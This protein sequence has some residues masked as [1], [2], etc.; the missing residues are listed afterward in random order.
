MSEYQYYEF[1]AIDRTLTAKELAELRAISTRASL[2]PSSF[3]NEYEWGDLKADPIKLLERYYDVFLYHANWGTHR[4]AFRLPRSTVDLDSFKQY[5]PK[6][7]EA[8]LLTPNLVVINLYSDTEEPEDSVEDEAWMPSL[9]PVRAELLGGDLRPLYLAWLAGTQE[10]E[11]EEELE[12]SAVEPPLPAGLRNLTPAQTRLAEFLRI[13]PFLLDVAAE[14]SAD[15]AGPPEGL[16]DWIAALPEAE[17][18]RLLLS[19]A[20]GGG[21]EARATLMQRFRR[22]RS[23]GSA[24][25]AIAPA[26]RHVRDLVEAARLSRDQYDRERER[27]AEEQRRL[28]AEEAARAR[29][30]R[31][32]ELVGRQDQ[33]WEKVESLVMDKQRASYEQA[34]ELLGDLRVVATRASQAAGYFSR[35]ADLKARHARKITFMKFLSRKDIA[36]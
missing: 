21:S 32:T 1:L 20:R 33:A 11:Q 6:A 17:K 5:L 24:P 34:V 19:L 30:S 16:E 3:V 18:N 31:L 26:P 36:G 29:E 12:E 14:T 7:S 2:T 22:E 35:L 23:G 8:L 27:E 4:I 13:D 10:E 25:A 9:A 15:E 28:R